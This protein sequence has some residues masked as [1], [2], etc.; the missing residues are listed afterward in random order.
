[1]AAG[2]T[3]HD[4]PHPHAVLGRMM[5]LATAVTARAQHRRQVLYRPAPGSTPAAVNASMSA[6]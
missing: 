3:K 4:H 2:L 6:S 1:V 5:G